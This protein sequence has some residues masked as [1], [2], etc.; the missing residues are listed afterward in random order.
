MKYSET[1]VGMR[2]ESPSLN[3]GIIEKKNNELHLVLVSFDVKN[4]R[5]TD[6]D[7]WGRPELLLKK[8]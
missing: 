3:E 6:T 4:G 1:K 8:E 7:G 2:V 5:K